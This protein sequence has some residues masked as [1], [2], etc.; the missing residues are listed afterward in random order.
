MRRNPALH[1]VAND[2]W[3]S[4]PQRSVHGKWVAKC[5]IWETL[6]TPCPIP[7]HTETNSS[8]MIYKWPGLVQH[9]VRSSLD[10]HPSPLFCPWPSHEWLGKEGGKHEQQCSG[11]RYSFRSFPSWSVLEFLSA[12]STS[13]FLSLR[14]WH[15]HKVWD[16]GGNSFLA[17]CQQQWYCRA[18]YETKGLN[19][20]RRQ[21]CGL[22]ALSCNKSWAGSKESFP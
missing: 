19:C 22:K 20:V 5:E 11:F 12:S 9:S 8:S 6:E 21:H 15:K 3:K 14:I 10:S 2:F 17:Q 7:S 1:C 13:Q 18:L 4:A 16:K